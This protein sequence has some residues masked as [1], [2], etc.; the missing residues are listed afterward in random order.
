M[1]TGRKIVLQKP[2]KED[3]PYFQKWFMNKEFRHWYDSYMNV[4]LDMIEEDIAKMK[5]ATDPAAD[6][7]DFAVKNKRNGETIGIASI[8]DIDRQN[9]HAEIV[10]GIGDEENRL[11]GFGVDLMIVLADVLFHHFGFEK[12]Y[13][14][15]NDNNRLGLKSALSF[16]FTAEGKLRKHTFIDGQYVDQWILGITREEYENLSIVPRWKA[17]A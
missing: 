13:C 7:I 3:A 17:R 10:L 16:G 8:K 14:K 15:I 4:S 9:G 12:C 2:T 1:F 6:R 5:D 11:A